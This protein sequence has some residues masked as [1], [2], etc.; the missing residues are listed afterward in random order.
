[1]PRA[2]FLSKYSLACEFRQGGEGLRAEAPP[3]QGLGE[4]LLGQAVTEPD[5]FEQGQQ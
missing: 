3:P 2:A 1:M 4:R 5:P